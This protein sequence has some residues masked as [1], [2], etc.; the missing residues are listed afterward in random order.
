[1]LARGFALV[2]DLSGK[3]LR[4]AAAIETGQRVDIEMSDGRLRAL[5]EAKAVAPPGETVPFRPKAR[6]RR[7]GG[8]GEGQ[9][10]LFES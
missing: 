7:G 9:G 2:R 8:G 6:R 1:M 5:A 3:P 4:T 10:S